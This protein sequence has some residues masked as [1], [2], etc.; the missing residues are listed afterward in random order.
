[1][2][3]RSG[4]VLVTH[5]SADPDSIAAALTLDYL[6]KSYGEN[7]SRVCTPEGVDSTSKRLLGVL[8][9][10]V[11]ETK[12]CSGR[13]IVFVDVSSLVQVG[14]VDFTEC[15]VVDHHV[16]NT[17]LGVCEHALYDPGAGATS[18]IIAE[19]LMRIGFFA[20]PR[21]YV[22]LLLA[23]IAFDTRFMRLS[24]PRILRAVA[25][26]QE[27]GGDLDEVIRLLT[28]HEV[29]YAERVARLK[30]LSRMGI[31]SVGEN[32]LLTITCVGA[33]EASSLRQ[34]IDAG[35]DIALAVAPREPEVRITIRVSNRALKEIGIPVAAELAR[36][37][38]ISL[39]GSG[40][41][42]EGAA[43]AIVPYDSL[44]NLESSI[45]EFFSVRGY[46]V[47][48]LENGRWLEECM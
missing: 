28:Q 5:R 46:K 3:S 7:T 6:L 11:P 4:V 12:E 27:L 38:G 48:V 13:R 31:Y 9:L 33:Y 8:G 35:S 47:R 41:G 25:W 29:P 19:M 21:S 10:S 24:S 2:W 23:G 36:H 32:L 22:T 18:T 44:I 37:L 40:G 30:S 26:L 1:M 34:A 17:L 43:G 20:L 39:G 15:S 45:L 42:H 16:V 14:A